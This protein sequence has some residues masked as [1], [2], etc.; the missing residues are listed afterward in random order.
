MDRAEE[1][2]HPAEWSKG[3][4]RLD[5]GATA[6]VVAGSTSGGRAANRSPSSAPRSW[7]TEITGAVGL[8]FRQESGAAGRL[9]MPEVMA[10]GV[11]LLDYD[12]DGDLDIYLTSGHRALGEKACAG[13][14]PNRLFRQEKD[15]TFS[16]V[17]ALSGLGDT[18]Y[19]MGVAVGD[20]NNDGLVDVY[21]T[22]LAADRLYRNR[23]EG[24]FE[25][26]TRA[27]GIDVAGWS[28]SACFFDYDRD[29]F[30]DLFV[31]QYV[32]WEPT[33]KCFSPVGALTYCGPLSFPPVPD[34]LL[35]N[36]GDGTF[37]DVSE[38]ASV[39][40]AAAAGL[41]VVCQD[42]TGDGLPD[43]YVANDAYPNNLWV[44][45]GKGRF[46]D[47]ALERGV[48]YNLAGNPEAGM[49]VLAEDFDNDGDTDLFMTHLDE[50][51]N[52]FYRN[53][54]GD[55]GFTDVTSSVGLSVS[56]LSLT[57]FGAVTFDV[58][59]DGDLDLH[60]VNGRVKQGAVLDGVDVP[61]PWD[62]LAQPNLFY[63]ND[64]RGHF[65]LFGEATATLCDPV[66]VT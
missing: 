48:A 5:P 46:A 18:C 11:A 55:L 36:R 56:S 63:L 21:V 52:T 41:G 14:T 50:E 38:R 9:L 15:G 12:N 39:S 22:N 60:L 4:A 37:E 44:N 32:K 25:D 23:G 49:G 34:V 59:L 53:L 40:S 30:L 24:R 6:A 33:K 35:H 51:S 19:G 42:L 64:G 28:A 7:F 45:R 8:R 61:P 2:A 47:E 54:G 16:D 27:A 43:V 58:E 20:Y 17:T 57:G 31:S 10:S 26:V 66:E 3:V 1:E 29:G 62:V 65:S 13:G